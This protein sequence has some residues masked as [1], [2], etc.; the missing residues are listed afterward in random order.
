MI[1]IAQISFEAFCNTD[2]NAKLGNAVNFI[3]VLPYN[4]SNMFAI[5]YYVIIT[6]V[7]LSI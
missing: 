3:K 7:Y 2:N 4:K 5:I 1:L 6:A